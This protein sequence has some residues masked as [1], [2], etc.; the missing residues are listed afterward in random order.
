MQP[1]S[2]GSTKFTSEEDSTTLLTLPSPLPESSSPTIHHQN[3]SSIS[4]TEHLGKHRQYWRDIILG[5]ND[6]LIST[7]LL[8]AGV[9]GSGLTNTDILLTAIAGSLA[10]AVSMASGEYVAT[11]SQNDVLQG[12]IGLERTHIRDFKRE[13]LAEVIPYLQLIGI[14]SEKSDLRDRL[15]AHYDN[16]SEALLKLMVALEFGVVEEEARSPLTAALVSGFLF[17]LGSLPSLLPFV[18]KDQTPQM[19]LLVAAVATIL[20]LFLVGG[21]KTWATRG[22]CWTAAVE[23]LT[24]AGCGG[25]LAYAVG[26]CFDSIVR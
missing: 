22:N 19:G 4:R 9:A 26:K 8:V 2:Y 1:S 21:F 18:A 12:E 25:F 13:E 24:I 15:M 17:F 7:F 10:G 11:K 23:N 16:D 6:G 14:P 3:S 20:S 5:I